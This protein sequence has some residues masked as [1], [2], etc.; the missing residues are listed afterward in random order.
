MIRARGITICSIY[1]RAE[2]NLNMAVREDDRF[3]EAHILL[4]QL[5]SDQRR[6]GEGGDALPQGCLHRLTIF[7][8]GAL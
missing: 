5:Y 1:D 4:G 7:C 2:T 6:L 3:Y 8:A